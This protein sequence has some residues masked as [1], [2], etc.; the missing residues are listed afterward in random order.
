MN[1]DNLMAFLSKIDTLGEVLLDEVGENEKLSDLVAMI[2][3]Y[4]QLAFIE[5]EKDN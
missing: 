2:M 4:T 3:D 1:V 5:I